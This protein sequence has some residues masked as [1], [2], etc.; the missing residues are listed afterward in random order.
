M[1]II[2]TY[3]VNAK[4]VGKA[5]KLC[6]QYLKRVQNSVFEGYI[7]ESQLQILK[8]SLF[9]IIDPQKD[10]IRIYELASL[11][12]SKVELLG[13]LWK[14]TLSCEKHGQS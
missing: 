8:K 9:K 3:D 4:R 11:K 12:Y 7:T 10:S 2:L 6:R 14:I 5:L 1:F 13:L